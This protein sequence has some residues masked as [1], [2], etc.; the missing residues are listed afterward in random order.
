MHRHTWGLVV[1]LAACGGPTERD[2][3][4]TERDAGDLDAGEQDAGTFDGGTPDAGPDDGGTS[5]CGDGLVT[6]DELCDGP[7]VEC[8]S[9]STRWSGGRASCRSGCD[10]YDVTTCESADTRAWELVRP[11]ERD[12]RWSDA[13]CNDGTGFDLLYRPGAPGSRLW[14]IWLQGGGFGDDV[15]FPT[16]ERAALLT[17]ATALDD[18]VRGP[19]PAIE[20]GIFGSAAL[21][22][23]FADAHMVYAHYCSSDLWS[24]Q[25]TE[26]RPVMNVDGGYYFA[27]RHNVRATFEILRQ[28]Y[29]LDD[30]D[31]G[32]R[33]LFGG[34]SAGN[35]GSAQTADLAAAQ[36]PRTTATGRLRYLGDGA[37]L[38][39]P[40]ADMPDLFLGDSPYADAE[41]LDRAID[42]WDAAPLSTCP[43]TLRGECYLGRGWYPGLVSLGIPAAVATS[44][45]DEV[46]LGL[47]GICTESCGTPG[48]VCYDGCTS[49]D[50]GGYEDWRA[51]YR[52]DWTAE[53]VEW[54]F[55]WGSVEHTAALV[56]DRWNGP[57][58]SPEP[59]RG[60]VADFFF[61]RTPPRQVFANG[62]DR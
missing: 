52:D 1:I 45:M 61:D 22:P 20:H 38:V 62:A 30:G 32:L 46:V 47:R 31:D 17:S 43:S 54:L 55:A 58:G 9:L 40:P 4:P 10:G 26:R 49:L 11:A 12:P 5:S 60:F 19:L 25:G 18:G 37:W 29:G 53:G 13:R 8:A 39:D 24:G 6:G 59:L 50:D 44:N 42:Y 2:A 34:E 57:L 3:G 33:V 48:R 36:L 21:N 27:G 56:D 23:D 7:T 14:V 41:L 51:S 28:R 15:A 16:A 35:I